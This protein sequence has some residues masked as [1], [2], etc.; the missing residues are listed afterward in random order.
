M[1]VY[2]ERVRV[3]QEGRRNQED[4]GG[5]RCRRQAVARLYGAGGR[6]KP[7][8]RDGSEIPLPPILLGSLGSDPRKKTVCLCGPRDVQPAA[9]EDGRDT[10]PSPWWSA[11]G[12]CTGRFH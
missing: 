10:S 3:A 4:D 5:C 1:G 8:L 11:M 9:L 12:S 6:G 7:N 2:P